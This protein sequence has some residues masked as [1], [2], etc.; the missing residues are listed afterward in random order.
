MT[1]V[2]AVTAWDFFFFF[3]AMKNP[4]NSVLPHQLGCGGSRKQGTR[5][6]FLASLVMHKLLKLGR[7]H[8]MSKTQNFHLTPVTCAAQTSG[9]TV[10]TGVGMVDTYRLV[11]MFG[12]ARRLNCCF[13]FVLF[14]MYACFA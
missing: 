2:F 14:Y 4:M 11:Q 3:F 1:F 9:C 12:K 5:G 10:V 6:K 8:H 13:R 7:D